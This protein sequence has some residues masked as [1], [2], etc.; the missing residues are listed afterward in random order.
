M[1]AL[2][3]GLTRARLRARGA[4]KSLRTNAREGFGRTLARLTGPRAAAPRALPHPVASILI[5]RI[6]GRMGNTMFLTPLIQRLHQLCPSAVIDVAVSFPW[7]EELL[8]TLPGVGR[9]IAF[10][11]KGPGL[12]RRYLRALRTL[13]TQYYDL[14][15]DPVPHS[16]G[17]RVAL[18][19][20][21]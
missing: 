7:A 13:R 4:S 10:P 9:V 16:T 1:V 5:C 19:L 8:R 14:A 6:N 18:S 17:G 21:R 11:H 2:F 20:C 15:I 12:V 3:E